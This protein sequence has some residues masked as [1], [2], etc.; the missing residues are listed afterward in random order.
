MAKKYDVIIVGGG[1]AGIFAAL[2]LSQASNLNILLVEKGRDIDGRL[3]SARDT[4]SPCI[5]CSPCN[6][7]C[8]LGGA[9]AF[10]DGKLT[11]TLEVGGRLR[12]YLEASDAEALIKYVDDIYL[13]FGASDKL[14]GVGDEVEEVR[15]KACL[16]GLRLIPV[17]RM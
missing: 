6:L 2:E 17:V 5:S 13:K 9:G 3:C 11:L 1:P 4:N 14:Y 15:R 10:S 12:D 8:G 7:V 16:V